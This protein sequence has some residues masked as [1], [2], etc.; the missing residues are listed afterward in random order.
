MNSLPGLEEI[1]L[2]LAKKKKKKRNVLKYEMNHDLV[3]DGGGGEGV[4]APM[5]ALIRVKMEAF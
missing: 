3:W 4:F 2:K 1:K 5:F